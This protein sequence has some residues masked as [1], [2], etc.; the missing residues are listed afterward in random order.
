MVED[1]ITSHIREVLDNP[2]NLPGFEKKFEKFKGD[3]DVAFDPWIVECIEEELRLLGVNPDRFW[4]DIRDGKLSR[5]DLNR[6]FAGEQSSSGPQK[7][8]SLVNDLPNNFKGVPTI[9]NGW[10]IRVFALKDSASW[11]TDSIKNEKG[12]VVGPPITIKYTGKIERV[13]DLTIIEREPPNEENIAKIKALVVRNDSGQIFRVS[14]KNKQ[15][16]ARLVQ[17]GSNASTFAGGNR[18]GLLD[19]LRRARDAN[20]DGKLDDNVVDPTGEID[21]IRSSPENFARQDLQLLAASLRING[22]KA[23]LTKILEISLIGVESALTN[24]TVVSNSGLPDGRDARNR[25]RARENNCAIQTLKELKE[26]ISG[27]IRDNNDSQ[28][29]QPR[30]SSLLDAPMFREMLALGLQ[31]IRRTQAS[32]GAAVILGLTGANT[33]PSHASRANKPQG[34]PN[35]QNGEKAGDGHIHRDADDHSN[36]HSNDHDDEH[37]NDHDDDHSH[38]HNHDHNAPLQLHHAIP[39][40]L[41]N[42]FTA[43]GLLAAQFGPSLPTG[44]KSPIRLNFGY[45]V[46]ATLDGMEKFP[47]VGLQLSRGVTN[48]ELSIDATFPEPHVDLQKRSGRH[49]LNFGVHYHILEELTLNL[50]WLF[51]DPGLLAKHNVRR[52]TE[53]SGLGELTGYVKDLLKSEDNSDEKLYGIL[54]ADNPNRNI[55]NNADLIRKR[56]AEEIRNNL[57]ATQIDSTDHRSQNLYFLR[58]LES[59]V[60]NLAQESHSDRPAKLVGMELGAVLPGIPIYVAPVFNIKNESWDRLRHLPSSFIEATTELGEAR[61]MGSRDATAISFS[62][63]GADY[64]PQQGSRTEYHML[65]PGNITPSTPDS[66]GLVRLSGSDPQQSYTLSQGVLFETDGD[67]SVYLKISSGN[68]PPETIYNHWVMKYIEGEYQLFNVPMRYFSPD[69]R[70]FNSIKVEQA[71]TSDPELRSLNLGPGSGLQ[72]VVSKLWGAIKRF[73]R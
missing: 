30:L 58:K 40:G 46:E 4:R 50:T 41:G 26:E 21:Q 67:K 31:E 48:G 60:Y 55:S 71:Y 20:Q 70:S 53:I 68:L 39:Y 56:I 35:H 1:V 54:F 15:P 18:P 10:P 2:I 63:L 42:G 69:E 25:K 52:M 32:H 36:D 29:F 12:D 47:L 17:Q 65:L 6:L 5:R 61:L 27:K 64:G 44:K 23:T 19:D 14:F 8:L 11:I 57:D 24:R 34:V 38:D 59:I 45:R 22:E 13:G 62:D 3:P 49:A 16:C 73:F 37:R 51:N 9:I 28:G 72:Y 43:P 7:L 33:Q 66:G